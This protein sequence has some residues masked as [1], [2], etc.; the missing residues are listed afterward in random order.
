MDM[1]D[2]NSI[3]STVMAWKQSTLQNA[4]SFGAIQ[5]QDQTPTSPLIDYL[6]NLRQF[7]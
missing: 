5:A 6:W 4:M 1:H 2:R 7:I 3:M